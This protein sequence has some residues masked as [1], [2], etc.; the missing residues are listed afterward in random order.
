MCKVSFWPETSINLNKWLLFPSLVLKV[1]AKTQEGYSL[2]SSSFHWMHDYKGFLFSSLHFTVTFL[3]SKQ[4]KVFF[5]VILLQFSIF[6][7]SS[8]VLTITP[9][10]IC[11]TLGSSQS[12]MRSLF[13][14]TSLLSITGQI[15]VLLSATL[16][17]FSIFSS[18]LMI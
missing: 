18:S 17:L 13:I 11:T 4:Q 15:Q 5:K 7:N 9:F 1:F 12:L 16:S 14:P 8:F 10:H 6:Q 3:Y 2:K